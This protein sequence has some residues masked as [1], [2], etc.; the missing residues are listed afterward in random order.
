MNEFAYSSIIYKYHGNTFTDTHPTMG[1]EFVGSSIT[2]YVEIASPIGVEQVTEFLSWSF[3]AGPLTFNSETLGIQTLPFSAQ[4]SQD[5]T[6]FAL[7]NFYV[8]YPNDVFIETTFDGQHLPAHTASI[9][10]VGTFP[11]NSFTLAKVGPDNPGN[12]NAAPVPGPAS[13]ILL[14]SGLI[15]LAGLKKKFIK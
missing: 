10:L 12:W 9:D 15:A 14:G 11:P 3:S 5:T 8:F 13:V 7:W 4:L 2:G 6:T 1:D